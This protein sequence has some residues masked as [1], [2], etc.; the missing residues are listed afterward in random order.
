MPTLLRFFCEEWN[1]I[2]TFAGIMKDYGFLRVAAAVPVVS[3]ADP[4]TNAERICSLIDEAFVKRVSLA[5]FPELCVT[6]YSCGDLFGQQFL[7]EE[8]EKAVVRIMEFTRGKD[9]TVV[10]GAPVRFNDR[11]Y[12][13]AVVLRNG[14]IKGIVPKTYLPSYNEFYESRWFSSGSDFLTGIYALTGRYLCN[15]KD[16]VREGFASEIKYAGFRCNISPNMLFKVGKATF[17]IEICED[18]WAP[19][20]PS[21]YHCLSGAQIVLNLSASNEVL[22]KNDYRRSLVSQQSARTI[23]AYVYCSSGAGESSQDLVFG[24]AAMISENGTILAENERFKSEPALLAADI[25]VEKLSVL[26]QKTSTFSSIAPDGTR[27]SSY[28]GLY[29]MVES[30]SAAATD[31]S[32]ELLRT[33]EPHPFLPSGDGDIRCN[34]IISMQVT[35]LASRLKHIGCKSAVVGISGGLDSTLAL[36]VAVLAFDK[37]GLK[38]SG[39]IGITMPGYGTTDRTYTNALDLMRGLGVTIREIPISA[40]CDRHFQ[41]IG[42]DKNIH[43]VTYENTQARERT[44]ILM[45]IANQTGGI[46]VGTG[47]LSELALGWATYNGDHMSMYGVNAGVPKTL[48]RYL[49][50][51]VSELPEYS[52]PEEGSR[53]SVRDILADIIDTPVS[54]ELLPAGGDGKIAQKTEDLVGP[55][56]LHDF[57]LYNFFRFGYSPDKLF[58]LAQ[59][60]F[61]DY[62][63]DVLLKW[64]KTFLRR[65]F[66][67]QFK[68]SCLPDGPKVGSVSLSPR[69][70]WRMPTDASVRAFLDGIL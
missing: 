47:D 14:N 10:V 40:A 53:R 29:S 51:W 35:G 44:Q 8:A 54:P 2:Y 38:R 58:F 39:I 24:G 61:P 46:V 33:V 62:G 15:G 28:N 48:V 5:V 59:K 18:M 27:S 22:F 70:D 69:G 52:V 66:A 68:R 63:Q 31:F 55:Y 60:A 34:E 42:H 21:S 16:S 6:G 1:L 26:R 20:P 32:A 41:D 45:D 11:L 12:N 57:Y 9:I 64:L 30:G 25:D 65:F 13:C 49:V 67:Q 37:A 43:D 50:K 7:I 19:V 4:A 56:E 17:A 23:S 36:L 3:L